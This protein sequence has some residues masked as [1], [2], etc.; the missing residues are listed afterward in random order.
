MK[1]NWNTA[2]IGLTPNQ[3]RYA[4]IAT[5][6]LQKHQYPVIPL[7]FRS[8]IVGDQP[9]VTD[10]PD[11]IENLKIVTLYIGPHRQPEFYDYIIQLQPQKVIF[12]PGTENP[13]FYSQLEKVGIQYEEA[14]T[15]VLLSTD[16]FY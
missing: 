1:V 2:V 16:S 6:R 11:Q 15:L 8:G 9:I 13:A 5:T 10:W 14:C 3:N 12:N 7:G 4:Y